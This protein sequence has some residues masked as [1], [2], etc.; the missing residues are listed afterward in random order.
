MRCRRDGPRRAALCENF[1]RRRGEGL[2]ER[3]THIRPWTSTASR[4]SLLARCGRRGTSATSCSRSSN[5][6]V[7][8]ESSHRLSTQPPQAEAS[9]SRSALNP[10]DWGGKGRRDTAFYELFPRIDT[11]AMCMNAPERG[12]NTSTPGTHTQVGRP[13]HETPTRLCHGHTTKAKKHILLHG[14]CLAAA[15][16]RVT[17]ELGFHRRSRL[18]RRSPLEVRGRPLELR[19]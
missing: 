19:R 16:G 3:P 9:P 2:G 8:T 15:P 6:H 7:S 11:Q 18:Q 17:G 4:S 5:Q 12:A 14:V 1:T 10:P 13:T